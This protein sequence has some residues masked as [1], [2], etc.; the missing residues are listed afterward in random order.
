MAYDWYD[1]N[2]PGV[3]VTTNPAAFFATQTTSSTNIITLAK[4]LNN[5]ATPSAAQL[6]AA[7]ATYNTD[8]AG[9]NTMLGQV[10]RDG[11]Q[12]IFLPKIDWNISS[13]NHASFSFN[14]MRWSSPAGIQTGSTVTR[15][16]NSFG[17]DFVKDTW[18]VAKLNTFFT[19]T[20]G[21]ELRFQYGRDFE[22]E[23]SQQP[24]AYELANL[25]NAPTF[26]NPLGLPPS[27]SITNGFT[28]GVP[29]FLQRSQ[30]PD[31][32]R[33]QIADT[34]TWTHGKH[35]LK[36]G[37]DFSHVDDNSQNLFSGF[38]VYNYSSLVSYMT[39]LNVQNGCSGKPC[40]SSF[41]QGLGLPGLD[42]A[43]KDYSVFVQDDWKIM[44]RLSLSLGMR[45]EYEQL[46][47][48]IAS[49][50]NP[51]VPQTERL[52]RDKNNFGPRVGFAWDIFGNSK[53]VLRGGYG[54]YYG[55]IINSTIFNALIVTGMPG[56]QVTA[57]F[58]PSTPGAPL[59]PQILTNLTGAGKSVDYFDSNF[60][61]PQIHQFDLTLEREIGWGTVVSA[62]YLGSLG[63]QLPN[64]ADTNICTAQ[65]QGPGCT[66]PVQTVNYIVT[67]NGP[68][69][70]GTTFSE[71][72]YR[73]R[74]NPAF[75]TMTD[76]FSGTNSSY[77]ALVAQVSHRM[78]HNIQFNANYTWSHAID[79]GQNQSTF[80]D[81][82]D[83][84]LPINIPN[85][86][87]AEKGNSI[88]DIP[89]RFVVNAVITSPW[90]KTGWLGYLTNDWEVAPIY[91]V[92]NGLPL[93]LVTSGSPAILAGTTLQNG[94]GSGIN[95]SGG[96][97]RL[98]Q[99]GRNN[100][101]LP[102]TW[103]QDI[104]LSKCFRLPGTIQGGINGDAF[105]LANKQNISSENGTGYSIVNP[106]APGGT[107][108]L[109]AQELR[110]RLLLRE[111]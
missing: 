57:T 9:L 83:T 4:Q 62:S 36:Y 61:A 54:I 58:T 91:Q 82:N 100:S 1:H 22:Y 51:A 38:G 11:T 60:Q 21:N 93:N 17:N 32:T 5:T 109:P 30:F 16:T 20:L 23:F 92:Q 101:R 19:P 55:R 42:F 12:N 80:S 13:K 103:V 2:F 85:A 44:P 63:R 67:G 34:M 35:N 94:L 105:N 31:E 6:S 81:T 86:I 79:F 43:T 97:T 24:S 28:F 48:T 76:I 46:P 110:Q 47:R 72:L 106:T 99:I 77:H 70:A 95:G 111:L 59:F 98:E 37:V 104:R 88:Y 25:V 14:R 108:Q 3:A 75:S 71:P 15:G 69:P 8:L 7:L 107:C 74:I 102:L 52:P 39:D 10:Q 40:Y 50:V 84:L 89:N 56:S 65:G 18:G 29:N 66:N 26:H 27:V 78:S 33:T 41:T 53:T 45:W 96:A 90:K 64:F 49:L 68:I 73:Q 87:A